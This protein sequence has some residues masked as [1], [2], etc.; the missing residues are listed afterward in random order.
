MAA[1]RERLR[2][3]VPMAKDTNATIEELLRIVFPMRTV[4]RCCNRDGLKQCVR[5]QARVEEGSNASTVALQVVGG[6]EKGSLGS[7]TVK[8]GHE[9]QGT[10]TRE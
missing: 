7:E 2:K 8:Y 9:S 6:E 10:R 5:R 3:H 1:V 4:P